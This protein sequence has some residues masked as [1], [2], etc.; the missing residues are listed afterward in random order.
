[1]QETCANRFVD[2]RN[3][4]NKFLESR[5]IGQAVTA[6]RSEV[7]RPCHADGPLL[8]HPYRSSA[9]YNRANRHRRD[10]AML[11]TRIACTLGI[12]L[13]VGSLLVAQDKPKANVATLTTPLAAGQETFRTSCAPCQGVDAK[14][15]GPVVPVLRYKPS[16]LTQLSKRRRKVSSSRNRRCSSRQSLDPRAWISRYTNLG[17]CILQPGPR[18]DQNVARLV[19]PGWPDERNSVTAFRAC[20]LKSSAQSPVMPITVFRTYAVLERG[21]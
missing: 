14:G 19:R 12:S 7:C 15:T 1:M 18:R 3:L 5:I 20:P 16:D 8:R 21:R 4:V 9:R 10:A 17:R 11:R 2:S 13:F 6:L